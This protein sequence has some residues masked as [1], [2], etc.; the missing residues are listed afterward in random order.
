MAVVSPSKPAT[1]GKLIGQPIPRK[2]DERLI[3]GQ[4]RY[5][6]DIAPRDAAHACFLRSIYAHARIVS[7]DVSA[8]AKAS[9]S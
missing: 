9:V 3:T 2:E 5:T 7:I 4:G 8:A 6:D 1:R